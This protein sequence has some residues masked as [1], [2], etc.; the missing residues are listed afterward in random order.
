MDNNLKEPLLINS[1]NTGRPSVDL[2]EELPP[3]V[4]RFSVHAPPDRPITPRDM[5]RNTVELLSEE[6]LIRASFLLDDAVNHRFEERK[7]DAASLRVY[8]IYRKLR[9]YWFF[10]AFVILHMLMI[11]FEPPEVWRIP[12][13]V[14][15]VVIL[16]ALIAYSVDLLIRAR[17]M[18][19]PILRQ[20]WNVIQLIAIS[21]SLADLIIWQTA[22][23]Y[24]R[25]GQYVR[26]FFVL[27]F[28][29]SVRQ[30]FWQVKIAMK[31]MLQV[32]AMILFVMLFFALFFVI[33]FKDSAIGPMYFQNYFRSFISLFVLFNLANYPEVMTPSF[34]DNYATLIPFMVY[35]VISAFFLKNLLLGVL[36]NFYKIN[37]EEQVRQ[38]IELENK[39]LHRA[40]EMLDPKG[41][42]IIN[43]GTWTYLFRF[44]RPRYS[45]VKVALL[46]KILDEDSSTTIKYKEF[47]RIV[48]LLSLKLTYKSIGQNVFAKRC[49]NFYNSAP[50]KKFRK[51]IKS[52]YF[53]IF[54]DL[55]ILANAIYV[56]VQEQMNEEDL[57]EVGFYR[58]ISIWEFS[59]FCGY[60]LE[61]I[62]KI[63]AF[64][65]RKYF[66]SLWNRFDCLLILGST[67]AIIV[68]VVDPQSELQ[69]QFFRSLLLLR[70]LR[71]AKWFSKLERFKVIVATI[72]QI[73]PTMVTFSGVLIAVFFWF[74]AIGMSIWAGKIYEDMPELLNTDFASMHLWRVGFNNVIQSA[75]MLF[76]LM[77]V[78]N[79]HILAAAHEVVS[80]PFA[81]I[82]FC[83][84]IFY[85]STVMMSVVSAFTVDA[86]V[87]QWT[88]IKDR[89]KSPVQLRIEQLSTIYR[90]QSSDKEGIFMDQEG[91]H[92]RVWTVIPNYNIFQL[93]RTV[94][95]EGDL[96]TTNEEL[97]KSA[98][99]NISNVISNQLFASPS[100]VSGS[101]QVQS[102][103]PNVSNTPPND[104]RLTF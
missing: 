63:F 61:I 80:T 11:F 20:P 78:N 23:I 103:I 1:S 52:I 55:M 100:P 6:T 72:Y 51:G 74:S 96:E 60:A 39:L 21:L 86:F 27:I 68:S 50:I 29:P 67:I 89:T 95:E 28:F 37:V 16:L 34:N 101:P 9:D 102:N 2:D 40:F 47:Q 94:I 45:K 36:Y 12:S 81:W 25:I 13:A 14:I 8:G 79:W 43:E 3:L 73:A 76:T 69:L 49:P 57:P 82:Y 54:V 71:L 65:F 19:D 92:K 66:R 10:R 31:E 91:S 18:K 58:S 75:A 5:M 38:G 30:A 64:G 26:P 59:F 17:F 104:S 70:V 7:Q 87:V 15:I 48:E 99:M 22:P 93:T 32:L 83:I 88:I 56:A 42:G 33:M 77:T 98:V 35:V 46:F 53:T 97:R 85:V 41:S 44:L 24:L 90:D 4:S 84:F 62:L